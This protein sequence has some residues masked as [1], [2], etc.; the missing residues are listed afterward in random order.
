MFTDHSNEIF[1]INTYVSSYFWVFLCKIPKHAKN[2]HDLVLGSAFFLDFWRNKTSCKYE[3]FQTDSNATTY[4]MPP[5]LCTCGLYR[6]QHSAVAHVI[7]VFPEYNAYISHVKAVHQHLWRGW[8]TLACWYTEQKPNTHS[9]KEGEC[10]RRVPLKHKHRPR[11]WLWPASAAPHHF[12]TEAELLLQRTQARHQRG[13]GFLSSYS[14]K[15]T[16]HP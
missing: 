2:P 7:K 1:L 12:E 5:R 16:L 4:S 13:G 3:Q 15:T 6:P 14:L 9:V 11:R 10:C 8:N